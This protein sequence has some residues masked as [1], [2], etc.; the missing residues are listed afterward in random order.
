MVK[1][2]LN[3]ALLGL[4]IISVSQATAQSGPLF[5]KYH[6]NSE[7]QQ[8]LTKLQSGNQSAIK[9]HD[10]ATSPG[11]ESVQVLEIGAN[12]KGV[13]AIFVGPTSKA[14]CPSQPKERCIWPKCCLIRH[15]ML[16]T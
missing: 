12:L 11:G 7:V 15:S 8:I 2:L 3:L 4:L 6:S 5:D 1:K 16:K 10:I 9:I 13:P 14:T